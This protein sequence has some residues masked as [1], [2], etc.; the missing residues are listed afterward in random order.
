MRRGRGGGVRRDF[1][2]CHPFKDEFFSIDRAN[3]FYGNSLDLKDSDSMDRQNWTNFPEKC[4]H[5]LLKMHRLKQK[6]PQNN[7]KWRL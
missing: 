3:K 7:R 1:C 5:L 6:N 2:P 4:Q